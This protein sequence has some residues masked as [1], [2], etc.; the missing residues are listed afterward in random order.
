V[1][2]TCLLTAIAADSAILQDKTASD[3]GRLT[4]LKFLGHWM[5]DLHQPLHISFQDDRGGNEIGETGPCNNDLHSVWDT[6]L[7]A[8]GIGPRAARVVASLRAELT[9]TNR[10]TWT[11]DDMVTWANESYQITISLNVQYCIQ[12]GGT[13]QYAATNATFEEGE[14]KRRVAVNTS[15]ITTRTPTVRSRLLKAGVRLGH[16]LNGILGQ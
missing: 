5:G 11:Q 2:D 6:C 16:L 3:A 9:D 8:R 7:I 15:Y 12:V 13:C 1:A 14:I 4:A 10:Q